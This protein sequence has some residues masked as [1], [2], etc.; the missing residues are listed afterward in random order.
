MTIDETPPLLRAAFSSSAAFNEAGI[1]AEICTIWTSGIERKTFDG[2]ASDPFLHEATEPANQAA[3][4]V[5]ITDN[6]AKRLTVLLKIRRLG[7]QE[8]Q[9]SLALMVVA[10]FGWLTSCAIDAA[11]AA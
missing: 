1:S 5:G 11:N 8:A 6:L 4:S 3:R 2:S 10:A 7:D 9:R